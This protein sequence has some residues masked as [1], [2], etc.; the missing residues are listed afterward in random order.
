ML[1]DAV[2]VYNAAPAAYAQQEQIFDFS[3]PGLFNKAYIPLLE[4]KAEFLHLYGSAG[5]G[6]SHFVAQKEII[7]SFAA[8]RRRRKTIVARKVFATLKDSCYALLK[9]VIYEWGLEDCFE[10]L[11]S[12]LQITNLITGVEFI[13]RGFDD[14]EKIKSIVDADR[15]WY[16][17]TTD[18]DDYEEINQ[19]RT[20]LRGFKRVQ[21]TLSYNPIDEH[22]W[23]NTEV[24]EAG[25]AGHEIHHFTY[26]DNER[27]LE[28]DPNYGPFLESTKD[29]DP[30][31]YRVYALGKWGRVIE[32]LIYRDHTV[33]PEFPRDYYSGEDIIHSYGLDFGF[34]DPCALVQQHVKDAWPKKLLINKE[35]LYEVG[36]DAPALIRRLDSLAVRKDVPMICD[37]ARPEMIRSLRDAG[38]DAR[39]SLKFPG[40]VLSGINEV[41]KYQLQIVAGSKEL[42]K[43]VRGYQKR[44]KQG[45]WLEEPADV[46]VDHGCDAFRY[47]AEKH[48]IAPRKGQKKHKTTSSSMFG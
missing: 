1:G 28:K 26:K 11:K 14:V 37:S 13:F 16:E 22:H 24:H 43:E 36:L 18:A 45:V 34:S 4:N 23:L 29:V 33:V 35:V 5:S 17:E 20:R 7:L 3:N 39:P 42:L 40:S 9:A 19:L 41:R 30:N 48:R 12:P 15:A 31:Y 32:G 38:Y 21:V 27:L 46:Q 2:G 44:K 25:L 8:H 10:I 6:K 47:A